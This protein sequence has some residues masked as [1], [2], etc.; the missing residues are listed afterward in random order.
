[1][2]STVLAHGVGGRSDLPLPLLLA[3]GGGG[4]AL[5]VSFLVLVFFWR[6][7][8]LVP[9]EEVSSRP[10]WYAPA[11]DLVR[12]VPLVALV[13]LVVVA[14]VAPVDPQVNLVPWFV[15]VTFW[16]GLV[17]LSLLLGPV[18]RTL[19]PLRLLHSLVASPS[20]ELPYP[21]HWGLYPAGLLLLAFTWLELVAPGRSS[22]RLLGLLVL[23]YVLV[24]LVFARRYGPAWF[25]HGDAFEVYSTLVS[26][27]SPW[28]WGTTGRPHLV[29][30]LRNLASLPTRPGLSFVLLVLVGSTAFD[31][32]LRTTW[33]AG[34]GA[35]GVLMDS[36]GFFSSILIVGVIYLGTV[37]LIASLTGD[38]RR[39]LMGRLAPSVVPVMV[40]YAIAHYFS[41][42]LLEGQVAWIL[43]SDPLRT[44]ADLFGTAT[45]TVDYLL[46]SPLL[47]AWVQ[48]VGIVLGH[49]VGT[50]LAHDRS[51]LSPRRRRLGGLVLLV[52]M[53]A[54]TMLGILLLLGG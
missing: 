18:W 50:V 1:M 48:I 54:L 17:P 25:E 33:W 38:S 53:L 21:A 23:V 7:S 37:S 42:F 15:Y 30:P 52:L 45:N 19:N 12:A 49:V 20:R 31:G 26:H 6:T 43:L 13:L 51:L 27:L 14:F 29:N 39:V 5:L 9:L 24:Q 36:L 47:V 40:G 34:L 16:V 3:V 35:G 11:K 22:P 44:G 41:F 10:S 4:L 32:L 2:T 46:V 8:H 28:S